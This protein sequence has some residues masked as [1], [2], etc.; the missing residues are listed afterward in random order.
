MS[1]LLVGIDKLD[2]EGK[3]RLTKVLD[4]TSPKTIILNGNAT[5]FEKVVSL[6]KDT[7]NLNLF[8]HFEDPESIDSL[9]EYNKVASYVESS[10]ANY[11]SYVKGPAVQFT[12]VFDED[13][14]LSLPLT[15]LLTTDQ[16]NFKS[17]LNYTRFILENSSIYGPDARYGQLSSLSRRK[18]VKLPRKYSS[19]ELFKIEKTIRSTPFQFNESVVYIMDAVNLFE[20]SQVYDRVKGPKTHRIYLN[21][22]DS[23]N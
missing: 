2:L 14:I 23:F 4:M 8:S 1:L 16:H 13:E 5:Y 12:N 10:V 11:L 20:S 15:K 22:V 18:A 6:F 3:Y 9:V 21:D 17:A 19:D 7:V